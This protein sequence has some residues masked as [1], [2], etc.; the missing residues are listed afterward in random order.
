VV[1][2]ISTKQEKLPSLRVRWCHVYER[3]IFVK[4]QHNVL[5]VLS[6]C[7]GVYVKGITLVLYFNWL[8]RL[9][10]TLK[11]R[12]IQSTLIAE[13]EEFNN[14]SFFNTIE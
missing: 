3:H 12:T 14:V 1:W 8:I 7:V 10:T 2:K 9:Q 13:E 11:E 6:S 4:T 5:M